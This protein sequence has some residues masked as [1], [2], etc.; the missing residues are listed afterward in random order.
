MRTSPI[1]Q[2]GPIAA[3]S[4]SS[5]LSRIWTDAD[6]DE[7]EPTEEGEIPSLVA[8]QD[9]IKQ[10]E[11][12]RNNATHK[13]GGQVN[14]LKLTGRIILACHTMPY[15]CQLRPRTETDHLL[16]RVSALAINLGDRST[17]PPSLHSPSVAPRPSLSK[18]H[19]GVTLPGSTMRM[20]P[21]D[22]DGLNPPRSDPTRPMSIT[23][24]MLHDEMH[25]NAVPATSTPLSPASGSVF[26]E[27][28]SEY[29]STSANGTVSGLHA[30]R[31]STAN[32]TE[33][34]SSF[35]SPPATPA[36]TGSRARERWQTASSGVMSETDATACSA[37][38]ILT[39]RRGHA[40]L[41]SGIRALASD[42]DVTLV[43]WP[44][45]LKTTDGEHLEA[46]TIS[47]ECKRELEQGLEELGNTREKAVK[48]APVWLDDK[49]AVDFYEGYCKGYL[50]PIFHYLALSD[51]AEKE[52]EARTWSAYYAA[53][54]AFANK[55]AE[56]Y[57]P[58]D[59]I[60][61]HDYHLLLLPRL[62]RER[63][64]DICIGIFIHSPFPSSEFFRCLPRREAI[65][66]GMLGAN[67]CCFQ[68][69][70]YG[71]HFLSACVRVMGYEAAKG[72]VE[73][74][75]TFC[76][77]DYCPI[78]IDAERIEHD[79]AAP[80]VLPKIEAIRSLYA[81]KRII[82]GRDKLDPTK[83]VI[84]KLRAYERFLHD[85]PDWI[86]QV[87]MIQVTSPAANDSPLIAQKVSQLVDHINAT[88]GSLHYQPLHHYH[89]TIE[90]DEYFA[91]LSAADLCLI[92][93]IRDGMNTTSMEYTICQ[94]ER[95]S[96]LI[97]SEFTGVTGLMK[98]ALKINPW[99]LGDVA[100][101]IDQALHMSQHEREYRH[102]V[103]LKRVKAHT[104]AVW[105]SSLIMKLLECVHDDQA[106]QFTPELDHDKLEEGFATAGKRLLLF[107]YD[108][109]LTP[110]VKTP[111]AAVPSKKLLEALEKLCSDPKNLCYIISGR[112][113]EFLDKHLGH[114]K[115]L[116]FSAEHGCFL[117][118]PGQDTWTDLT[119]SIDMSWK[120]DVVEIFKYYEARTT[121][122][123][124]ETKKSS[125]TFH[126]RNADPVYGA[127]QAKECQGILESMSEKLPIDVLVG[128]KNVE[129][130]PAHTHKGEI[131]R[132]I[133]YQN[134]DA[135][136]VMCAGDDKTDEDMFRALY[137]IQ[138]QTAPG[139]PPLV[140]P[141]ESL[142]MFPALLQNP[143]VKA[144]VKALTDHGASTPNPDNLPS[145]E[146]K[147]Q[148]DC[149]YTIVVDQNANRKTTASW[150]ATALETLS[151]IASADERIRRPRAHTFHSQAITLIKLAHA[152]LVCA[153]HSRL[154][155]DLGYA[156]IHPHVA[157]DSVP[158]ALRDPYMLED[159]NRMMQEN[160]GGGYHEDMYVDYGQHSQGSLAS[161]EGM[162]AFDAQLY[163]PYAS[164]TALYHEQQEQL[165]A[166]ATEMLVQP[167]LDSP[168]REAVQH[169]PRPSMPARAF[170]TDAI[171]MSA[172]ASRA[173]AAASKGMSPYVFQQVR[174]PL[175]QESSDD[176]FTSG[177]LDRTLSA[178]QSP[179]FSQQS[180]MADSPEFDFTRTGT[181]ATPHMSRSHS[182][183]S[184]S[185]GLQTPASLSNWSAPTSSGMRKSTS[186]S[187]YAPSAAK[188][189]KAITPR[190]KPARKPSRASPPSSSSL[191]RSQSTQANEAVRRALQQSIRSDET[192]NA[193]FGRQAPAGRQIVLPGTIPVR[194]S[195]VVA[196]PHAPGGPR[197]LS[198]D[199]TRAAAAYAPVAR[200]VNGS[201]S[202]IARMTPL[203]S[204][205]TRSMASLQLGA[206]SPT[207][208]RQTVS[209][210]LTAAMQAIDRA[211]TLLSR[212]PEKEGVC[213]AYQIGDDQ[214]EQLDDLIRR[215]SE[216]LAL[217]KEH[218]SVYGQ[219]YC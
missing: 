16:E 11:D 7:W 72:G 150:R 152:Q 103:V 40:A 215:A 51:N 1:L 120:E 158:Q 204:S 185:S 73:T 65:L 85:Y 67:L 190:K 99:D 75:G 6:E 12:E 159:I 113:G 172:Q 205:A 21:T 198:I 108:G 36:K 212:L 163:N 80:G 218:S 53:N 164:H 131:V 157:L 199:T 39:P 64:P 79:R 140:T 134:P 18:I 76:A 100:R 186:M 168:Y 45:D 213:Q 179:A 83:G 54:V 138:Q 141:P 183:D 182:T 111:S 155:M 214:L 34:S 43:A 145:I 13:E 38:W 97:L 3:S 14:Q 170:T 139:T 117:R 208:E 28:T 206:S 88:Y 188:L 143:I 119:E 209:S 193:S 60:Y 200:A 47:P 146:S 156:S 62:L 110:I 57:K 109:T 176:S 37:R 149:I 70:S 26:D 66:D 74:N 89:Q 197:G 169:A 98:T 184:R 118:E 125:T 181:T 137:S 44:G 201:E 9:R 31:A 107:D 69:Y 50:W 86:G 20:S 71:R 136:F 128:K 82:L 90:R 189:A 151:I 8:I 114:I 63:F 165:P 195:H 216:R 4:T 191:E 162:H 217:E 19:S 58:G 153:R 78:G 147:L 196:A 96:P 178:S 207:Q 129:V 93:S 81:D 219:T 122:S 30:P 55:I 46:S 101:V 10:L 135:E 105:S 41:N 77:I 177:L 194:Q 84:P 35:V 2:Q 180:S 202:P 24:A 203:S 5:E 92:T 187:A 94:T 22:A 175:K 192:L 48:C 25:N 211:R 17:A 29:A 104:A 23:A 33:N 52:D 142:K 59:L 32:T 95:K 124:V 87:V 171:S 112:D 27:S 91:L 115:D 173:C 161:N 126:Y 116:G 127:F 42:R 148:G 68:T 56:V 61:I 160:G 154:S 15:S 133:C 49:V 167:Q 102:A 174:P 121:G 144:H 123:F 166:D 132:R 106:T 210:A 130:R